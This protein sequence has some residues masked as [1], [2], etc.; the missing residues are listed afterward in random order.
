MQRSR[1]DLAVGALVAPGGAIAAAGFGLIA[2][3]VSADI[4]LRNLGVLNWPW[5]NEV[6]EY[7]L[8][9]STFLGAPWVLHHGGHVN[10]DILLRVVPPAVAR[11]TVRAAYATGLAV[12]ALCLWFAVSALLDT[13]ATGAQVFK[14][15]VFPEWWLMLPLVWCFGLCTLDFAA[16][17]FGPVRPT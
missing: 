4:L 7:L 14:N 17:L 3:L 12:S 6:T 16:R 15:L 10:V 1:A 2:L 8:T 9:I 13:R 5:L 11:V